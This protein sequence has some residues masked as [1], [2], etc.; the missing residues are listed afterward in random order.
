MKSHRASEEKVVIRRIKL[1]VDRCLH[2]EEERV[3]PTDEEVCGTDADSHYNLSEEFVQTMLKL[4]NVV[5]GKRASQLSMK[6]L[7]EEAGMSLENFYA[8]VNANIYKEPRT[9]VKR[10]MLNRAEMMLRT[11]SEDILDIAKA[12]RFSSPNYFIA[13]FFHV[14]R[15]LPEEY[16]RKR[17]SNLLK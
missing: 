5:D 11:S 6:M 8:L 12:C 2:N 15:M 14:Y 10:V 13:S 3:E 7:S 16:R 4:L 1:F 9:L 17:L